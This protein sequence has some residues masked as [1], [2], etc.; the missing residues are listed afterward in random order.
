MILFQLLRSVSL[1]HFQHERVKGILTILGMSLG[2][3]VYAGIRFAST[4]VFESFERSSELLAGAE[5][6]F[7]FAQGGRIEETDVKNLFSLPGIESLTPLSKRYVTL[8][9]QD[10]LDTAVQVLGVD[11]LQLGQIGFIPESASKS[12][13]SAFLDLLKIKNSAALSAELSR[14]VG[15]DEFRIL[16]DT[17]EVTIKN[18]LTLPEKGVGESFGGLTAVMDIAAYQELFQD[19]GRIDRLLIK[20][21][22]PFDEGLLKEKLRE[23]SG[24]R[25]L[26]SAGENQARHGRKMTEAFSLNLQFLAGISLFV[27]VLLIYNSVSY[28]IL[29]RRRELGILQSLGV[30]PRTLFQLISLESLGVGLIAALIGILAGYALSF[31]NVRFMASSISG[32]YFPVAVAHVKF[33][34]AV[35]AEC[36]LLG[37]LLAWLGCALPSLEIFRVPPRETF[38]Y[39]NFESRFASSRAPLSA[40]GLGFLFLTFVFSDARWLEWNLLMGFV[41]PAL[42]ILGFVLL[43]PASLHFFICRSKPLFRRCGDLASFLAL[44]H[45]QT[46]LQ[47]NSVA[48]ASAMVA[49]GMFMGMSTLIISFRGTVD[50]WIGHV[51]KA[52]LFIS[53]PYAISGAEGGYLPDKLLQLLARHP[54]AASYDWIVSRQADAG[55]R[56]IK[57]NGVRFETLAEQDRLLYRAKPS[58]DEVQRWQKESGTVLIS[59]T[60]SNRLKI[61]EGGTLTLAGKDGERTFRVGSV[62]FDYSSDQGVVLMDDS[63]FENFF[64][65]S[66]KQ[67]IALYLQ[68]PADADAVSAWIEKSFE[69]HQIIVRKNVSLRREVM[70]IFDQTFRITKALQWISL[71]IAAFA[72][73]NTILMLTLERAREFAVLRALGA[74]GSLLTKMMTHEA[75]ILGAASAAGG[76]LVGFALSL[77]LVFVINKFFFAWSVVFNYPWT[78]MLST[79]AGT[80]MLSFLCGWLPAQSFLKRMD[81]GLL[82]YE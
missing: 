79:L 42:L 62:F 52:D 82:R 54:S 23:V 1:S 75:L 49:I 15:P 51:T 29:K 11:I 60:L 61:Q 68:N 72:I 19:Y 70:T 55:G 43:V 16:R 80:L 57:I 38:H 63:V 69:G 20:T 13:R 27:A 18:V 44:D 25:L 47:R 48:V 33:N 35:T 71:I 17:E 73:L 53:S 31:L 28:A 12:P 40:A 50:Q 32:L 9:G 30:K 46:T 45:I 2:I 3:A 74:K 67:G 65:E 5:Q 22:A 21:R 39:Q 6:K 58:P 77:I 37:P 41:P 26:L 7:I 76:I 56:H 59:E 10:A 64:G 78:L 14:R 24:G 8:S 4:N 81:S 36:L 34:P 66:R